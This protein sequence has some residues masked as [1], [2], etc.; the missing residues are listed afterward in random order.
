MKRREFHC[1]FSCHRDAGRYSLHHRQAAEMRR[2]RGHR[3]GRY[4]LTTIAA[5]PDA[6]ANP[7]APARVRFAAL[8]GVMTSRD[9][10][11]QREY[12]SGVTI[13]NILAVW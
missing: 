1:H 11:H 12:P 13:T 8:T 2:L 10:M 3:W 5:A 7:T 6:A 4:R 9:A